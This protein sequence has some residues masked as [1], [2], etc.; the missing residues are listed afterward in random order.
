MLLTA[1]ERVL[2]HL[3][4]FWNAKDPPEAIT[5]LGIADAARLRRSHV[6]RTVKGLVREGYLEERDGRVHSRGRRVKLYYLTE[7]GL[8]RARELA[9]ALEAQTLVADGGPTTLGDFVKASGRTILAIALDLD[10]G[11]RYRGQARDEGL[12]P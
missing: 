4:N 7:A 12:P 5:Q 1:G 6:P 3:L 8:R 9:Q 11:G 10:V 2:L